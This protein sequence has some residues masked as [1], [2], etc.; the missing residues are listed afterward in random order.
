MEKMA[1]W[2]RKTTYSS[3]DLLDSCG[4]E[5]NRPAMLSF[6]M[7]ND[8]F[9]IQMYLSNIF[10]NPYVWVHCNFGIFSEIRRVKE[11]NYSILVLAW[12]KT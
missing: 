12:Y 1:I 5:D 4:S 11:D 9:I 6:Q 10:R 8:I 7:V 2:A 3:P